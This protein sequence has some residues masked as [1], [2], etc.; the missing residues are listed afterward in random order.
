MR[1][2]T[3]RHLAG[4]AAG[5]AALAAPAVARAE[6]RRWRMV[7]S[8]PKRL[9]GPGMSAERIAERIAAMSG[10]RLQITVHA[11]GE[12][13]PAFEVLDAVGGGVVEMGHTA[14]FY[15]QGKQPAA[16]FYTTV[17][18]GL[19]PAEHVA[20]VEAG[21]GQALWD[22]L[23]APFGAK[24][25]MGGNT[26]VCMGGWFR[27]PLK[28]LADL[29]GLKV[30]SLGLG[31]EVYR[32]L[33]ATPQTTAPGEILV[34]LQSGVLDGAE[35]VGPG[36][37]IALGLYRV[38]P[39][40][41][42]PGFNKPNGTGECLVA[43]TAWTSLDSELKAIVAHACAAEATY[44]LSEMERLNAEAL[45]ALIERHK[46]KLETFPLDI[47][48]AARAQATDVL[49]GIAERNA[50][51]RKVHD[52]YMGFRDRVAGWSRVSIRA[53]LEARGV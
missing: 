1:K 26:G 30:R 23:Y 17:P 50:L 9:P 35:F 42:G 13:V 21:G 49:A 18:F 43:L 33:G 22:E 6:T 20:W 40:Y 24:P 5:V 8:W 34:S 47:V 3:R 39:H 53:V 4:A 2:F 12:V 29:K 10:G 15:W 38:A 51:A 36:T 14:A 27:Q 32:R 31:G 11:A 45:A 25:F 16:A 37:D 28:G 7:T 44:A 19:T 46:V 52:S 41:V 48:D